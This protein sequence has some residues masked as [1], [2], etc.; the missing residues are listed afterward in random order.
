MKIAYSLQPFSTTLTPLIEIN[1][2][3]PLNRGVQSFVGP[4]C[5]SRYGVIRRTQ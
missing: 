1:D 5:Q 4:V 3:D 2:S